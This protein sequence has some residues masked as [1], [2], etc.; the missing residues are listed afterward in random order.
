MGDVTIRELGA[1]GDLGWVVQVHGELYARELGWTAG[2]E[3]LVASLVSAYA[4]ERDPRREA[5]WIAELDGV[6]VGCVFVVAEDATTARLRLLLVDDPARGRRLGSRLVATAL[7]FARR[8]DYDRMV[9][10]TN[11]RLAA[12]RRIYLAAGFGLV[13][14]EVHEQFGAPLLGQTYALDLAPASRRD[15]A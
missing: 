15:L 12:A 14:E 7:A 8:A 11:D 9:L 3:R 10:W 2:F 1:P 4:A 5:A 13:H 6:R